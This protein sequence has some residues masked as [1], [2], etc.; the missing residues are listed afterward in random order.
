MNTQC[1]A[2]V[3]SNNGLVEAVGTVQLPGRINAVVRA[4]VAEC[5]ECEW[6]GWFL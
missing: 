3:H 5:S 2:A 1:C 6:C 4:V